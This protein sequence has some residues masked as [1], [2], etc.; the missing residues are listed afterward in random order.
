MDSNLLATSHEAPRAKKRKMEVTTVPSNKFPKPPPSIEL[1]LDHTR[2]RDVARVNSW[3]DDSEAPHPHG[4]A[5]SH[6]PPCDMTLAEDRSVNERRILPSAISFK[7]EACLEAVKDE[8]SPRQIPPAILPPQSVRPPVKNMFEAIDTTHHTPHAGPMQNHMALA[9][10]G[11]QGPIFPAQAG[12]INMQNISHLS[13]TQIHQMDQM[14]QMKIPIQQMQQSTP[15]PQQ[16]F[17]PQQQMALRQRML[18]QHNL[19]QAARQQ[20]LQMLMSRSNTDPTTQPPQ[21]VPEHTAV[22]LIN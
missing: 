4:H 22:N 8:D 9:H 18:Q 16:M 14:Q 11:G 2:L 19:A 6:S 21:P 13:A 15:P 20:A 17:A 12:Q 10:L 3:R 7:N 5:A 1:G